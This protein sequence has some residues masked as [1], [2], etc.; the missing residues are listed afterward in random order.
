MSSSALDTSRAP[1]RSTRV[2][3]RS[4]LDESQSAVLA[5]DRGSFAVIGAPGSGKT[6]TA[7][8]FVADRIAQGVY[9]LDRVLVLVPGRAQAAALRDRLAVRVA[10]VTRGP[11]A[12]TPASL[13]YSLVRADTAARGVAP[14]VLL[15]GTEHDALVAELLLGHEEGDSPGPSWPDRLSAPVR[16]TRQF[17]DELRELSMRATELGIA[18]IR[19]AELG[20]A[21]GRPEWTAA[22]QFLRE[23]DSVQMHLD[24]RRLDSAQLIA[25]ARH[26][27]RSADDKLFDLIVADDAQDFDSGSWSLV[28]AM[29]RRGTDVVAFGDPDTATKTF[30][31]ARSDALGKLSTVLGVPTQQPVYL[32]YVHRHSAGLRESVARITQRVGASAAGRQRTAQSTSADSAT[33]PEI[34]LLA[35]PALEGEHIARILRERK[36]LGEIPYRDMAVI[37][38]SNSI[39]ERIRHA[40]DRVGIPSQE[41]SRGI[42]LTHHRCANAVL[43]VAGIALGLCPLDAE[44]VTRL[45][46]SPVGGL[47]ALS[48]RR[49]RLALR[50]EELAGEGSR[51]ADELLVEAFA[52]PARFVT[53]DSPAAR[54]AARLAQLVRSA[55]ASAERGVSAEELLWE[56]WSKAGVADHLHR[57][58]QGRGVTARH[59]NLE[60]DAV[61]ALFDSAKRYDERNPGI[62]PHTLINTLLAADVAHDTLGQSSDESA[63]TIA[64]PSAV[65]G[66]EFDTVIV[67]GVQDGVWPNLRLRGSLLGA[68]LLDPELVIQ[69]DPPAVA[70][71]EVLAD[72]LRMFALALSRARSTCVITAVS[73]DDQRPSPLIRLF[74]DPDDPTSVIQH[75]VPPGGAL[76]LRALVGELRGLLVQSH[77]VRAGFALA[78]LADAAVEGASPAVWYGMRERTGPATL[79]DIDSGDAR[80]TVSPSHI[81]KFEKS[82]L[83]WFIDRVAGARP[84][85]AMASGTLLHS[86]MEAAA[87]TRE[88]DLAELRQFVDER[89]EQLRFESAWIAARERRKVERKIAGIVDYL[90]EFEHSASELVGSETP[91]EFTIGCALIRGTI[92]RLEHSNRGTRIIDLKTGSTVPS[93]RTVSEHIQLGIYQLAVVDGAVDAVDR[94]SGGAALLFV[95]TATRAGAPEFKLLEQDPLDDETAAHVRDRVVTAARGMA[96]GHYPGV[97]VRDEFD[98]LGDFSYRVQLVPAVTE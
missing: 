37:V 89:W 71:R 57:Q 4:A 63:V 85:T 67:A 53:I 78:T 46:T 73:D 7:I 64:T 83:A 8:E 28:S 9:D 80:V 58:S 98:P 38:R 15:T 2:G 74:D 50:H 21:A 40:L 43:T 93:V 92:D 68:H 35:S 72:E 1:A 48:V 34:L 84:S 31:G 3:D 91:F 90:R 26:V 56:V 12:R 6:T 62:P 39:A 94:E 41:A 61:V 25:Q 75:H 18:P 69:E 45:L 47:D 81:E 65:V 97:L 96:S 22:A 5:R 23:M 14:P 17:R 77:D 51:D 19:L 30:R 95:G 29:A 87:R 11:L 52:D 76:T 70:R 55:E 49:L 20:R 33:R 24:E 59:A 79:V 60:L 54:R 32:S 13:A 66:R 27:L 86:A 88:F 82:P 44:T 16:A 42:I 36:L 10:R